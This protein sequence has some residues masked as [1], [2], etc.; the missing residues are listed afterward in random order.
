M[1]MF[2]T[3]MKHTAEN[4]SMVVGVDNSHFPDTL[5]ASVC[6]G[7]TPTVNSRKFGK[8]AAVLISSLALRVSSIGNTIFDWPINKNKEK[9]FNVQHRE[10]EQ[11]NDLFFVAF[12]FC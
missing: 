7:A 5:R 12:F 6:D 2:L 8:L 11:Q 3:V 9:R 4:V 1:A 10:N